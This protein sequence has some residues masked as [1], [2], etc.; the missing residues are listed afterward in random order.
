MTTSRTSITIHWINTV[1]VRFHVIPNSSKLVMTWGPVTV[2]PPSDA[3]S[4]AAGILN[5]SSFTF[6]PVCITAARYH[7]CA[8]YGSP[9]DL[10][11]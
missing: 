8:V 10:S 1:S 9:T 6:F 11:V 2:N 4:R 3:K 7:Y 5:Q